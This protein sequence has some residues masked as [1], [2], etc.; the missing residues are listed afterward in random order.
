MKRLSRRNRVMAASTNDYIYVIVNNGNP[1][2]KGSYDAMTKKAL[3]YS[4]PVEI[5]KFPKAKLNSLMKMAKDAHRPDPLKF[6]VNRFISD[7]KDE[8]ASLNSS[9][10]VM[11]NR[12]RITAAE[13]YGWVVESYEANEAYDLA[14]DYFGEE[15]LNAQIVQSLGS[16]ELAACL[17]FIFRMNDFREWDEYKSGNAE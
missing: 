1:I 12:R 6:A 17:A 9:C 3:T 4:Y 10:D 5:R 16:D 2:A 11:R 14:A 7:Y 13:S 15:D 8:Y